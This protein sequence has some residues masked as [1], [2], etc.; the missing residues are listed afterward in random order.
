MV[1]PLIPIMIPHNV[2]VFPYVVF[3][4]TSFEELMAN[5]DEVK[6]L[7][8][9]PLSHLMTATPEKHVIESQVVVPESFPFDKI[10]NGKDYKWNRSSYDVYFFE[11]NHKVIWGLTAKITAAFIRI[12]KGEMD[13]E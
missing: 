4:N 6:E 11:Y 7:F 5:E 3:L 12:L 8:T 1:D 9:V 2:M 10:Q 13:T